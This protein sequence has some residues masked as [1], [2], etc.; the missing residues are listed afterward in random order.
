V[1]EVFNNIAK[2]IIKEK[3]SSESTT[4]GGIGMGT[5]G[6]SSN[7]KMMNG[8]ANGNSTIKVGGIDERNN[9]QKKDKNDTGCC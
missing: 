8:Y 1:N 3:A 2:T 9:A 4:K 5:N 6:N 7:G